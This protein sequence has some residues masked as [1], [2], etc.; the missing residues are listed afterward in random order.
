M[1][2][3]NSSE[4][5]PANTFGDPKIHVQRGHI[6]DQMRSKLGARDQLGNHKSNAGTRCLPSPCQK[7]WQSHGIF[8]ESWPGQVE[9]RV[10]VILLPEGWGTP[11]GDVNCSL[12]SDTNLVLRSWEAR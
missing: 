5:S 2:R 8:E 4:G 6:S 9:L 1:S 10:L 7:H 3:R 12:F 11:A